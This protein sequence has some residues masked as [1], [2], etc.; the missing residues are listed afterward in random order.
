MSGYPLAVVYAPAQAKG[1]AKQPATCSTSSFV[2]PTAKWAPPRQKRQRSPSMDRPALPALRAG[3]PGRLEMKRAKMPDLA[4]KEVQEK[5]MEEL[6][7]GRK[8]ESTHGSDE[9]RLRSMASWLESW[10]LALFPPVGGYR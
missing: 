7:R 4:A 1:K 6:D 10:N 2:A 5:A 3:A 9:F 8:A